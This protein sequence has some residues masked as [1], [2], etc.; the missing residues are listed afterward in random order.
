MD[1]E[2]AA[3]SKILAGFAQGP[4]RLEA[5]IDGLSNESLD[6]ALSSQSWSI[7]QIVHHLAD[8][9][10]LWKGFIKQAIGCPGTSFSL[11]WYWETPQDDW[12]R[13]WT[14]AGRPVGSSLALY[15]AC[16]I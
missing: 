1:P 13:M 10:D 11:S 16:H 15:R 2:N 12:A 4:D 8:G 6:L 14:Y 3:P 7:R 5:A 9:I